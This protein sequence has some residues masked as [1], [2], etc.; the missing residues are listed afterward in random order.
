MNQIAGT[1]PEPK[2]QSTKKKRAPQVAAAMPTTHEREVKANKEKAKTKA[3]TPVDLVVKSWPI[4]VAV[5]LTGFAPEWHAMAVSAGIWALR[6]TF[7]YAMLATH[8]EI[9]IDAQ[10]A[11]ILPNAALF[12]Q[13]PIDGLYLTITLAR[14]KSLTSGVVQI[15]LI[16]GV[17]AL[18]LWLLTYL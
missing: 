18:V 11:A 12:L 16:H 2:L 14:G 10:M 13:I 6:F 9:G 5:L 15:L 4:L 3:K 7:P 1:L 8:R 17:C